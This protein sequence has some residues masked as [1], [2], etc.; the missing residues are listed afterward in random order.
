[1]ETF[2]LTHAPEPYR[3]GMSVLLSTFYK[4]ALCAFLKQAAFRASEVGR[5]GFKLCL[6]R[7]LNIRQW[8]NLLFYAAIFHGGKVEIIK[9]SALTGCIK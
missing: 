9:I 2:S 7:F 3:S 8:L 1:M 5:P 4:I 6:S